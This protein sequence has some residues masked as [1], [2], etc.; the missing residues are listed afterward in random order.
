MYLLKRFPHIYEIEESLTIPHVENGV[1]IVE[2]DD[3]HI[4]EL[5]FIDFSYLFRYGSFLCKL[6]PINKNIHLKVNSSY[7]S[8]KEFARIFFSILNCKILISSVVQVVCSYIDLQ[9]T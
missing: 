9:K 4:V 7:F 5:D 6:S 8:L 1:M 2:L 3:R